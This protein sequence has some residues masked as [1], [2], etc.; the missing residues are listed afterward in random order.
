MKTKTKRAACQY[1]CPGG[2]ACFTAAHGVPHHR[3]YENAPG[4]IV[5][6]WECENCGYCLPHRLRKPATKDSPITPAQVR[7]ITC[8]QQH[9]LRE[10]S[11]VKYLHVKQMGHCCS[12]VCE[13]G[14]IGDEGT[15]AAILCRDRGHFFVGR[16]GKITAASGKASKTKR[17]KYPLIYGWDS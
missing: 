8:I 5:P 17:E 4:E 2:G 9:H 13:V 3:S 10:G 6:V 11:E 7:A 16:R 15:M 14:R 12:V 1:C